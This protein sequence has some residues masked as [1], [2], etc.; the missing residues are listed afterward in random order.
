[1]KNCPNCQN[2]VN[3]TSKFCN[4][5]GFN[6]KEYEDNAT[7]FC[8]E[9]GAKIP[10]NSVFCSECGFKFVK[11]NDTFNFDA[12]ENIAETATEQLY[13]QNGL[14]VENGVLVAYTGK[15][16]MVFIPGTIEEIFDGVFA[17]NSFV[18]AI[19]IGIGV[20]VIGKRAFA[21]CSS[22]VEITVPRTCK[23]VC[24]DAFEGTRIE[25]LFLDKIDDELIKLFL[26]YNGK[27]YYDASRINEC[28]TVDSNDKRK[29]SISKIESISLER[30][31]DEEKRLAEERRLEEERR[32]RLREEEEQRRIKESWKTGGYPTF[33]TYYLRNQNEKAPIEWYVL[34]RDGNK[35]L[36]ISRYVIDSVRYHN[37]WTDITWENS[38]IR[39]WLNNEFIN[40]AFSNDERAKIETTLVLNLDNTEKGTKGGNSTYDRVFLLS[41]SEAR[42]YFENNNERIGKPTAY[43]MQKNLCY[44]RNLGSISWWLRSPG[45]V[46][47]RAGHIN[48][49]GSIADG[50]AVAADG[51]GVRPALWVKLG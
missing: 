30:K 2:Q 12:L 10:K 21:N 51:Y 1:M 42:K 43:A 13:E 24:S 44:N 40:T 7:M 39:K 17:N 9:C 41:M 31:R 32:I 50:L 18:T 33:G 25:T 27:K 45:Q 4:K 14:K 26:S 36:I 6:I 28:M 35:A 19:E 37:E 8:E 38:T 15:K 11:E 34:A 23:N 5:C 46:Q 49:D 3:D 29:I 48:Y 22:L 20:K 47:F 16:R